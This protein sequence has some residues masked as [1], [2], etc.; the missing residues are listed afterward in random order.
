[1]RRRDGRN[2][3]GEGRAQL[4]QLRGNY[5]FKG[6]R[7]LRGGGTNVPFKTYTKLDF[8][9]SWPTRHDRP[10]LPFSVFLLPFLSFHAPFQIA[11]KTETP[12]RRALSEC[13]PF[14]GWIAG[15]KGLVCRKKKVAS[16]ANIRLYL[17]SLTGRRAIST[18]CT[19]IEIAKL[20]RGKITARGYF[21]F[22]GLADFRVMGEKGV[23]YGDSAVD[24][25][26]APLACN[27]QG[28]TRIYPENVNC[29]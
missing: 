23:I 19:R 6:E 10:L 16:S 20:S 27:L 3:R 5:E 2:Q 25:I 26:G 15:G 8:Q 13:N 21:T 22:D 4:W 17:H 24:F 9:F 7:G 28:R 18:L 1:M 29:E 11:G 12:S 14:A